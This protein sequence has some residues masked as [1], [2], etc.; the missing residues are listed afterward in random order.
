MSGGPKGSRS[1]LSW[2][3]LR[4]RKTLWEAFRATFPSRVSE[5]TFRAKTV[6]SNFAYFRGLFG[7]KGLKNYS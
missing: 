3:W 4:S 7:N 1:T 5:E 2:V 6:F